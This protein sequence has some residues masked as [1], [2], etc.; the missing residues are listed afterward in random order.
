MID[1]SAQGRCSIGSKKRTSFPVTAANKGFVSAPYIPKAA[2]GR[3]YP[4]GPK[5]MR[6]EATY[7]TTSS[8][9]QEPGAGGWRPLVWF[10]GWRFC[11]LGCGGLGGRSGGDESG[12]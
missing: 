11:S 12:G 4:R 5:V 10:T 7:N 3:G 6:V 9:D 1:S 8:V 2:D